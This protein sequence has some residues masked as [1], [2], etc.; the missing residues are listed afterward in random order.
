MPTQTLEVQKIAEAIANRRSVS[1]KVGPHRVKLYADENRP[2]F[3]LC[4]YAGL[5]RERWESTDPAAA[6]EMAEEVIGNYQSGQRLAKN[7][8]PDRVTALIEADHAL[9]GVNLEELVAHY[10]KHIAMQEVRVSTAADLYINSAKTGNRSALHQRT[11]TSHLKAFKKVFCGSL[12]SIRAAELDE[13][14][15]TIPNPKT[16]LNHRIT[17]CALFKFAQRKSYLPHGMTEAEKTERPHIEYGEP[18]ILSPDDL[19]KILSL[20]PDVRTLAFIVI[21]AFAGCRASEISR[22]RWQDVRE[23]CVV[24]GSSKTKTRRRRVA[25]IPENLRAWLKPLRGK[26]E[27]LVTWPEEN[28]HLLHRKI[29]RMRELSGVAWSK[30]CLRHT[31]VSSHLELHRDPPRTSKTSGHS[32]AVLERDYLKL[33]SRDE[34]AAWFSIWPDDVPSALDLVDCQ[35]CLSQPRKGARKYFKK[36]LEKAHL[37]SN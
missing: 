8:S 23:D 18:E 26:P 17:I 3:I 34:A 24:L 13:Y 25:E 32:L 35:E 22:L 21:G 5:K 4:W 11:I 12:T 2:R 15:S 9:A 20:C 16:R 10:R 27:D 28:D 7:V 29:V 31:F 30:N 36:I 6:L 19:K 1:I 37:L 33:L 14:L